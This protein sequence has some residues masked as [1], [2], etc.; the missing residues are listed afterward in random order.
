MK[1]ATSIFLSL[2]VLCSAALTGA[3][4]YSAVPD[5]LTLPEGRT[6][7]GSMHGTL[8]VSSAGEVYVSVEG[9]ARQRFAI[10]GPNPGLQVYSSAG[11]YLR[12]VPNA[13]SDLHGF[14][15]HKEPDGDFIYGARLAASPGA[16]DQTRAGL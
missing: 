7:I 12:N 5:W 8:A 3:E 10:L 14:V 9:S 16:A 11:R 13:P 4:L 1:T 2:T 15:V 6:E